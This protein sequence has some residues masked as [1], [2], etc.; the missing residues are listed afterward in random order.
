MKYWSRSSPRV[1]ATQIWLPVIRATRY[2]QQHEV[3]LSQS[4][5]HV[6]HVSV[7]RC[8]CARLRYGPEGVHIHL[9]N[10]AKVSSASVS[11]DVLKGHWIRQGGGMRVDR[12]DRLNY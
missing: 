4:V 10:G 7:L 12:H 11:D 6:G 9:G 3:V 2:L 1:C 5:V 8:D